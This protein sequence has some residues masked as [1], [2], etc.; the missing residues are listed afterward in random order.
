MRITMTEKTD[1]TFIQIITQFVV[2][3]MFIRTKFQHVYLQ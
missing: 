3:W 2:A 1:N